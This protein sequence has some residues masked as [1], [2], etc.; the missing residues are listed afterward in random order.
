VTQTATLA[1]AH[2]HGGA[3]VPAEQTPFGVTNGKYGIWMFLM[4]DCM[5]FVGFFAAY[6]GLRVLAPSWP[7]PTMTLGIWLTALMTFILILSSVTMVLAH[8]ACERDDR[9][10]L[11]KWLGLTVLGG[12]LFLAGQFKEYSHLLTLGHEHPL[13]PN[14]GLPGSHTFW[15]T[16]YSLTSFHGLHVL[17]GVI[18]L[19]CIWIGAYRG[20]YNSRNATPVEIVG[21]YWHFVDL[22]WIVL[23]TFVYLVPSSR[24]FTAHLHG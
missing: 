16:F 12:A 11:L 6:T 10:G 21:L 20:K 14:W 18:Y 13:M 8:D 22:V 1:D 4:Q 23:F 9:A 17:V 24:P 2:G 7:D 5:G 19:S 3:A 15:G